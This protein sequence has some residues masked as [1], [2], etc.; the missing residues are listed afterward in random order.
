VKFKVAKGW[1]TANNIDKSTVALQRYDSDAASWTAYKGAILSEDSSYIYYS[2]EI[3][4]LSV[5]VITGEKVPDVG[6]VCTADSKTC[7]G[8]ELQQCKSD[9]SDWEAVETC[10]YGCES[11]ACKS[12][13]A[14]PCTDDEKRCSG[15][16]V[17][18]CSS[19]AWAD[20]ETC[21]YGC[22]NNACKPKPAEICTAGE[23]RCSGDNLQQC[24]SD[25]T[26]WETSEACSYGCEAKA[27]KSAPAAPM[28]YTLIIAAIV[29]IILLI[30]G[31]IYAKKR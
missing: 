5:F 7:V 4:G 28:D 13:P 10:A 12:E 15:G 22:E 29:I 11:G 21:S 2:V 25:G 20:L 24:S 17:Q 26:A 31:V 14:P 27:C 9:G 16:N 1:I 23:K 18:Q 6:A 8:D 19:G 30:A 3:P